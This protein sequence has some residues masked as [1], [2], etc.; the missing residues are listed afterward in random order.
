M[1]VVPTPASSTALRRAEVASSAA[2]RR[3]PRTSRRETRRVR[4]GRVRKAL[5]PNLHPPAR[6]AATLL[7]RYKE[8]GAGSRNFLLTKLAKIAM[9]ANDDEP[10]RKTLGEL[11]RQNAI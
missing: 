3:A 11:F 7:A 9:R 5:D 2:P 8:A 10:L 4:P 1:Q 6:Y